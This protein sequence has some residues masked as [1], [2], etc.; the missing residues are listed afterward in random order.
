MTKEEA[1]AVVDGI[2]EEQ[3]KR[4]TPEQAVLE[5]EQLDYDKTDEA[6]SEIQR[7][8]EVRE[9]CFPRWVKEGRLSRIDARD[10]L[11]RQIN[12]ANIL[13]LVLDTLQSKA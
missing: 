9:R 3:P 12:A 6:L 10:R 4:R 1:K 8:A 13:Q 7:E 11:D 2:P 5:L